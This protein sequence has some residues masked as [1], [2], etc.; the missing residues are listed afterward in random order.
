MI[1]YRSLNGLRWLAL[2]ALM[3]A[4][5]AC[6]MPGQS[7][8]AGAPTTAA[9]TPVP[10]Q[11]TTAPQTEATPQPAEPT[12]DA[13]QPTADPGQPADQP[14]PFA[15]PSAPEPNAEYAGI[16]FY[17][18]NALASGWQ[19]ETVP[20]P[21]M[22]TGA[23][24]NWM[25]PSHYYFALEGY[26]LP[27]TFHDPQIFVIPTANYEDF[28]E[29]GPRAIAELTRMLDERPTDFP[30]TEAGQNP[31]P[32][33]PT[34]NAAQ[35]VALRIEYLDF[36]NG[37]GLRYL[38]QYGQALAPINN[39]ELFYTFQG[40]TLDGAYYV[41]VILPIS[42][43]SLHSGVNL[44]QADYAAIEADFAGHLAG[45]RA[46]INAADPAEFTPDLALLDQL[47]QS[48]RVEP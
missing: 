5:L 20:P 41:S 48:I 32:F 33:L 28:N 24:A 29:S 26:A 47:V 44:Q 3:L 40:L 13:A 36:Q 37:S 7:P 6:T 22:S 42:H 17:R 27:D 31:L 8:I 23:P 10:V 35:V 38:T 43:P 12:A 4:A 2:V 1:T 39:R 18:D 16:S 45:V 25:T 14:T 34:F 46:T 30:V 15:P 11:P 21:D 19:G 9:N